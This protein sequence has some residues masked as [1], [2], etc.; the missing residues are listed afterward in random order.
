MEVEAG[1]VPQATAAVMAVAEM[2]EEET[3]PN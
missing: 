3:R 2:V 1:S